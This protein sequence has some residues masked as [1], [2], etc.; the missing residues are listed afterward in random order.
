MSEYVDYSYFKITA[1]KALKEAHEAFLKGKVDY[2]AEQA[3]TAITD[4]RLM[5]TAMLSEKK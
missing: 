4:L 5:R 2:A 3:L 1:E